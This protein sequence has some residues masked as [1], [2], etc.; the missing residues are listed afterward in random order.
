MIINQT[1]A[2]SRPRVSI[3]KTYRD[4]WKNSPIVAQKR[5][6]C[7]KQKHW[8]K[9]W[10]PVT[11]HRCPDHLSRQFLIPASTFPYISKNSS[12]EHIRALSKW[13]TSTHTHTHT[14]TRILIL[15]HTGI[16]IKMLYQ[17]VSPSQTHSLTHINKHIHSHTQQT[18]THT[19][20]HTHAH[21][22][23][24]THWY[25]HT[26]THAYRDMYKNAWLCSAEE[27][28]EL[29]GK[30]ESVV[31][32]CL[33]R[34]SGLLFEVTSTHLFD[35]CFCIKHILFCAPTGAFFHWYPPFPCCTKEITCRSG[36]ILNPCISATKQHFEKWNKMFLV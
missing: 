15:M 14:H 7:L 13:L 1:I 23:T 36:V 12:A 33:L 4:Q 6:I 18:F 10:V 34:W 27:L 5:L 17:H 20:T 16:C 21:T 25:S 19:H 29:Y 2:S 11:S 22:H 30:V 28:L 3:A 26:H 32:N 24:L 8:S 31:R 35:Q 9:R